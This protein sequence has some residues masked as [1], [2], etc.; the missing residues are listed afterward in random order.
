MLNESKNRYFGNAIDENE[1]QSIITAYQTADK[2]FLN[3]RRPTVA[4]RSTIEAKLIILEMEEG[5]SLQTSNLAP[6]TEKDKSSFSPSDL[7]ALRD[8]LEPLKNS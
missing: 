6:D 8:I 4:Y 1:I 7:L 5:V 2:L 3:E